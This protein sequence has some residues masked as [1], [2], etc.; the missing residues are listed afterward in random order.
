MDALRELDA[1]GNEVGKTGNPKHS[2]ETFASQ[3]FTF[4]AVEEETSLFVFNST[5]NE[6]VQETAKGLKIDFSCTLDTGSKL[7]ITS[8]LVNEGGIAGDAQGNWTV[9]PGDFKWNI[10]FKEWI[11]HQDADSL[12]LDIEIKG[13]NASPINA[14]NNVTYDLNGDTTLELR[15]DYEIFGYVNS[16]RNMPDG[17]PLVSQMAGKT[18]FTFKFQNDGT[19]FKY[20]P[21][22]KFDSSEET[23]ATASLGLKLATSV[24]L[25]VAGMMA[26]M[27]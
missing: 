19:S 2:I 10:F 17:Y 12:E 8:L 18:L 27:L 11:W 22:I 6:T 1:D 4:S 13:N 26:I 3:D 9:S 15:S 21:I 23:S 7:Q 5:S 25:T 16:F 20:D 14:G 24:M